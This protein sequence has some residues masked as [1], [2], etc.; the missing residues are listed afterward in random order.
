MPPV[1]LRL[2][3]LIHDALPDD[4]ALHLRSLYVQGYASVVSGLLSPICAPTGGNDGAGP[5]LNIAPWEKQVLSLADTHA[6]W[7]AGRF[8]EVSAFFQ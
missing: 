6:R 7:Q 4:D 3:P 2:G 8:E 1:F 5:R